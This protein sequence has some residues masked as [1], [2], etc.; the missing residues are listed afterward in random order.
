MQIHHLN[1]CY[2]LSNYLNCTFILSVSRKQ[3]ISP[4]GHK[5]SN[6]TERLSLSLKYT[7]VIFHYVK[8]LQSHPTLCNPVDCSP[9]GSSVH[10]ILQVR[11]LEWV[12]KPTSLHLLHQQVNSL[13]LMPPGKPNHWV[14]IHELIQHY[15]AFLTL[16]L[17]PESHPSSPC[18]YWET[19]K[20]EVRCILTWCFVTVRSNPSRLQWFH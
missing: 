20:S 15:M 16:E 19:R 10:G 2:Y 3:D 6:T 13:P 1:H 7:Q 12:A 17:L 8:S 14:P 5:E 18:A 11:I 9:Q 4:W